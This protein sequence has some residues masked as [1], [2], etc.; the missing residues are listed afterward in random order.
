MCV[1]VCNLTQYTVHVGR[2]NQLFFHQVR[3]H[4][5][6][7]PLHLASVSNVTLKK[8]VS[9]L[10]VIAATLLL[11]HIFTRLLRSTQLLYFWLSRADITLHVT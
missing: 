3:Y 8:F 6:A 7:T 10:Y 5:K 4:Q 11:G 2:N 1:Y 9:D